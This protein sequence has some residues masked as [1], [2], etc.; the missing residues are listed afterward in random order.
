MHLDP[1]TLN[2]SYPH[3]VLSLLPLESLIP[4]P[5]TRTCRRSRCRWER[6]DAVDGLALKERK[7]SRNRVQNPGPDSSQFTLQ[8][9]KIK[10][11]QNPTAH[12]K[13]HLTITFKVATS[14]DLQLAN[15]MKPSIMAEPSRNQPLPSDDARSK[16][17]KANQN[18]GHM[19][20]FASIRNSSSV[21]TFSSFF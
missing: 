6:A 13:H 15:P 7:S 18:R 14:K 1:H 20:P 5:R 9:N 4:A 19:S 17:G 11:R 8:E 21:S 12:S 16:T 2:R 3:Q 10:A